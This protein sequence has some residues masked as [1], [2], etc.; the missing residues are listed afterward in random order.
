M[1]KEI[2]KIYDLLCSNCKQA[3]PILDDNLS[4]F[5]TPDCYYYCPVCGTLY[6][7]IKQA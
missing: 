3:K 5:F 2:F 6:R 4:G 1:R 7:D